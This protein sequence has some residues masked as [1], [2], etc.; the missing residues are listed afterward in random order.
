MQ[1]LRYLPHRVRN[2]TKAHYLWAQCLVVGHEYG[3]HFNE[4]FRGTYGEEHPWCAR[5]GR[6]Q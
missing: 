5:C 6:N 3:Q 4:I 1:Q 2:W